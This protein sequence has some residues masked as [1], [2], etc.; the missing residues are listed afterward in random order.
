[1]NSLFWGRGRVSVAEDGGASPKVVSI[2]KDK[3]AL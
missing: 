1:M 2:D 3:K